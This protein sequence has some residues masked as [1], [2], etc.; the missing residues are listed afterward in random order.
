M[1]MK[2]IVR[3][4]FL[5]TN[6]ED[7][8]HEDFSKYMR[9]LGYKNEDD[10]FEIYHMCLKDFTSGNNDNEECNENNDSNNGNGGYRGS[11]SEV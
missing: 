1:R 10:I 2:N 7:W 6:I 9:L 5:N 3:R 11:M 8:N 4:Y